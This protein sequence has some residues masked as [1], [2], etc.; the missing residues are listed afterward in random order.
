[1]LGFLTTIESTGK[2]MTSIDNNRA[3]AEPVRI[4]TAFRW[5]PEFVRG[6]ARD[7][8]VRWALEEA[9]L[10]YQ[11]NLIGAEEQA[12]A[13]Y[14]ALQPFGQVPV[15]R[16]GDLTLFESGAIAHH[17]A[18]QSPALMPHDPAARA[19]T[20]TW[21][22]AALNSVEPAVLALVEIDL[23]AGDAAW[24][25]ER[26]PAVVA[27]VERRFADLSVQLAGR[28][29]LLDRFSVA[30]I[31]MTSVLRF[32]RHTELVAAQ[33]VLHAYLARCNA[34]P[35]ASKAVADHAASFVD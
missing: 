34:R 14:R 32:V 9:G 20:L 29:Y 26:R 2:S 22:F 3:A 30:D 35:A 33:P 11:V 27:K 16:E 1:M 7:V 4:L 21:M 15:Y 23:F 24:A 31:L 17:I 8:R 12:S 5:L 18:L 19:R 6:L 10:T 25:K 13:A 28:E